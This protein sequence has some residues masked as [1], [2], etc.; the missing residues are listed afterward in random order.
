MQYVTS[1]KATAETN[2]NSMVTGSYVLNAATALP[3]SHLKG[4]A[5]Y[6]VGGL[7]IGLALGMGG[8][9]ITALLS[10]RLHRRD[11]VAAVL[12]APVR[13]SV[14]PLRPRRLPLSLPRRAAK[15][16]LDMKR[17]VM[18]LRSAVPGGSQARPASRSLPSTTRGPSRGPSR[19]WPRPVPPRGSRSWWPIF[20]A[21]LTGAPAGGHR[22]RHPQGQPELRGPRGVPA[23]ARLRR[24]G[25]S[26]A[27]RGI[28]GSTSPGQYG[29]GRRLLF[30]QRAAYPG[31]PRSCLRRRS[32]GHLGDQ[33]GRRGDGRGVFG[34]EDLQCRRNDKARRNAPW[35]QSSCSGPTRATRV[36]V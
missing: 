14:G 13:L 1:T 33:R 24:A 12:G 27:Q 29:F 23:G 22:P 4:A 30:G 19:H 11:E 26:S 18:Y 35:I 34:G 20:P 28:L 10:R 9:I 7:L 31:R 17:V 5:L 6:V 25:R 8:V 15:R 36:R 2:T 21:V 3:R 32:P 16:K